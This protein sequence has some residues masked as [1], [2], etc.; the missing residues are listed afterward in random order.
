MQPIAAEATMSRPRNP[1]PSRHAAW[2]LVAILPLGACALDLDFGND[3]RCDSENGGISLPDGFCASVVADDVGV[4]RHM[5]VSPSGDLFV[6]LADDMDGNKG[7]VMAL[8]DIDD[9]GV[10]DQRIRFGDAGGNGIVWRD[11]SLYFAQNDR[12][13]RWDLPDGRLEP[14]GDAEIV[15][16]DL[17]D[18]GDHVNKTI[19]FDGEGAMFVNIGS[20]SNSCQVENRAVESPGVD[21]CPE[22]S[23]RAGIWR[24]GPDT[25]QR[26]AS[27]GERYAMGVRNAV[28]LAIEPTNGRLVAVQNG[29]DQLYENWPELYSAED[30]ER[31]P[32]EELFVV[33]EGGEYGWPYCYYDDR[34]DDKVLAPEYG[35]DGEEVGLCE[36]MVEPDTTYPAHWAPL[37]IHF[38]RG[39]MF[40]QDYRNGAFIAFHGNRFEPEA[41]EE[42][43]GYSVEFQPFDGGRPESRYHEFADDFVGTDG[44]LPDSAR[45]RPVGLAEAPDGSL[46][47]SDDVSGRI[48]RV[49]YG[50]D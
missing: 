9:D 20:A 30:D 24:Y 11:D 8:H 49:F 22:L 46:Y 12:I 40:P 35:G 21:P 17:P 18:T 50:E 45:H 31:L 27:E 44:P 26:L 23:V 1:F 39:D 2:A 28:A 37:S 5:T 7:G 3:G 36:A 43:P 15:V 14:E 16:A 47:I 38:Y 41:D 32:A 10:A 48:W 33:E 42:L 6:A 13:V 34:L 4:A 25:E 29:R 19:V